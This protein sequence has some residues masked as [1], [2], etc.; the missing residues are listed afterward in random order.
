MGRLKK[1][2]VEISVKEGLG[3]VA[4]DVVFNVN[5]NGEFYCRVPDEVRAFFDCHKNYGNGVT[6]NTDRTG[7]LAIYATTLAALEDILVSALRACNTPEITET[8][9]ILYNL[10]SHISFAATNDGTIFPNASFEGAKWYSQ[11][12]MYG[13]HHAGNRCKRG[14]SLIIGARAMTK[15]VSRIGDK[16]TIKYKDYYKGESHLSNENP[17]ALLNSWTAFDLPE[18]PQEIP[19]SDDAAIFFHQILLG[20]AKLSKNIQEAT[21]NKTDLLS[22]IESKGNLLGIKP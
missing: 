11:D 7:A 5:N 9:V 20:M 10:E 1:Q 16:E 3:T 15:R 18:H 21:F 4:M 19:Y 8:H 14:F 6:C 2:R 17:A 12:S 13:S 22:L